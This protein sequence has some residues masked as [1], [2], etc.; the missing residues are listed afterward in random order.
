MR[1]LFIYN[2]S[3]RPGGIEDILR[4]LRD[5]FRN[6][7]DRVDILQQRQAA[8]QPVSIFSRIDSIT[9]FEPTPKRLLIG[10]LVK[11]IHPRTPLN[12]VFCGSVSESIPA[13]SRYILRLKSWLFHSFL[14]ISEYTRYR[15]DAQV[16][17]SRIHVV[18]CPVDIDRYRQS[19]LTAKNILSLGRIDPRKRHELL[20]GAFAKI[21]KWHPDARLIILGGLS[22]KHQAYLQELETFIRDLGLAD[23]VEIR[24]NVPDD[25]K[26]SFLE[27][28]AVYATASQHEMFGIATVEA[29]ASGLPVVAF[30]NSA[31]H[32]LVT[33]SQG[34]L[35]HSEESMADAIHRLLSDRNERMR[36]GKA[37]RAYAGR[38]ENHRVC[39]EYAGRMIAKDQANRS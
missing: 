22:E 28:A 14:A 39:Q 19:G 27:N 24:P 16:R 38:F 11:L 6:C 12:L 32:E 30:D 37:A 17:L 33:A 34:V 8:G 13:T 29:L 31:T 25:Q 35:V 18:Y 1:H 9:I 21:K 26:R 4:H 15:V 2:Y 7:G 23:S 20:I 10:L 5:Y 36:I 3:D